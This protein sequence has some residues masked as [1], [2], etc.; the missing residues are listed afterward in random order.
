MK[1]APGQYLP[2][3]VCLAINTH[4]DTCFPCSLIRYCKT[5]KDHLVR[6]IFL[7]RAVCFQFEPAFRS[8]D[9]HLSVL[10]GTV[11]MGTSW[12]RRRPICTTDD[13]MSMHHHVK[14]RRCRCQKPP[15]PPPSHH[16]SLVYTL[17]LASYITTLRSLF[18]THGPVL[19]PFVALD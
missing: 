8:P 16:L 11:S 17:V 9:F 15:W 7:C 6:T 1:P 19:P 18:I 13:R 2:F 12:E 10:L 4:S 5:T 3:H 14:S